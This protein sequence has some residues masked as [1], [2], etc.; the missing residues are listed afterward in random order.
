MRERFLQEA[1]V[2]AR[3]SHPNIV[4]IHA[5]DEVSGHVFYVMSFVDGETL[6]QRVGREGPIN[7]QRTTRLLREVAWAL[8]YAHGHG[9]V[10]RDVKPANILI[11]HGSERAMVTDFG[12][13]QAAFSPGAT[14]MGDLIGTPEYMSPE[15]AR[16]ESVDG[17]GD[18]YALGA[19]G[20]VNGGDPVSAK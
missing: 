2:A 15:Q 11:E 7:A 14:P 13:A 1:R 17:R 8:A 9:I 3:L 19:V 20:A 12:I 6:A 4:A 16:G 10:H 5:V 18:L